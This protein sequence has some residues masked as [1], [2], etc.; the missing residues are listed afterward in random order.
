LKKITAEK[1]DAAN[2]KDH[3]LKNIYINAYITE[4]IGLYVIKIAKINPNPTHVI[5][6]YGLYLTISKLS[7]EPISFFIAS[8]ID[9]V[10][11]LIGIRK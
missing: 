3:A 6:K 4:I 2:V 10:L 1:T 11:G 9:C 5:Q 8:F 7:F